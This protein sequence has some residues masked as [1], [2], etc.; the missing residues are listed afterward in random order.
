VR[1]LVSGET[2][3]GDHGGDAFVVLDEQRRDRE[4]AFEPGQVP[5]AGRRVC[6]IKQDQLAA[7]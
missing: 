3:H 1:V 2:D 5:A 7:A 4:G 6:L